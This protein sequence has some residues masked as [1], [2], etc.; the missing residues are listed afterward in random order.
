MLLSLRQED[1]RSRNALMHVTWDS[2]VAMRVQGA[3]AGKQT[4]R[5]TPPISTTTTTK[6]QN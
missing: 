1:E 3:T 4:S 6:R 2:L 5:F